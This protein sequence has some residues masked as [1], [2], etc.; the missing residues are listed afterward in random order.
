M[1]RTD[2]ASETPATLFLGAHHVPFTEHPY[3][4]VERGGT[5]ESAKQLQVDEHQVIKTL[6]R[7]DEGLRGSRLSSRSIPDGLLL[8]SFPLGRCLFFPS[9]EVKD[10]S[11]P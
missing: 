4:Y 7:L 10:E 1:P 6:V 9:N 11:S 2:H 8:H 3:T 5:A